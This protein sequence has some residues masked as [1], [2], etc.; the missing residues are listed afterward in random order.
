MR[1]LLLAL[2]GATVMAALTAPG[3]AL[4]VTKNDMKFDVA[5]NGAW[6]YEPNKVRH[7]TDTDGFITLDVN[8]LGDGGVCVRLVSTRTTKVFT[9]VICWS[10]GEYGSKTIATGVRVGT[11]FRVQAKKRRPSG[12]NNSWGAYGRYGG[13]YY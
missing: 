2:A 8:D 12:S 9:G 11:A 6:T 3:T 10:A 4:A 7:K 5:R 1:K 13:F